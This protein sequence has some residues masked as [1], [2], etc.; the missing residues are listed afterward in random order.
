MYRTDAKLEA[1]TTLIE[2]MIVVVIF[3]VVMLGTMQVLNMANE[4]LEV[5]IPQGDME[6]I[7]RRLV[8]QI[9]RMVRSSGSGHIT[10]GADGSWIEFQI[11][12]DHDNDG[13]VLDRNFAI[14]WGSI[15]A[16]NPPLWPDGEPT[17]LHAT[18]YRFLQTRTYAEA[19]AGNTNVNLGRDFARDD[20]Y[21]LGN[22][23]FDTLVS[24]PGGAAVS[25]GWTSSFGTDMVILRNGAFGGDMD[26]DAVADPIFALNGSRLTINLWLMRIVGENEPILVNTRT[27]VLLRN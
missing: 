19:A 21:A 27:T 12:V 13:D 3:A 20:T 24:Y 22:I 15:E 17:P 23:V 16:P 18:R 25:G 14:Q 4:N 11:P 8:E 2:V 6:N 5:D 26:G 1:G 10:V 7:G 9:E